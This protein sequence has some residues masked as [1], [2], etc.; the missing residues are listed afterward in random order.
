MK[1]VSCIAIDDE[2][3]ALGLMVTHITKTPFL[4]L[5]GQFDNALDAMEFLQENTVQLIFLDIHM[6]D[7]TG[8][9][10]ARTLDESCKVIFT[11]AYQKYAVEGF[12]LHALDYLLKPISYVVFLQSAT[13]AKKHFALQENADSAA[14]FVQNKEDDYLF[15]KV[16]MQVKRIDYSD[17]LYLEGLKDYV[18]LHL[19]SL[20]TPLV[21][22]ATM[23]SLETKLPTDR[24][25][26]IHRSYIV[27]LEKIKAIERYRILF[28]SEHIPVSKQYKE[29]FDEFIKKKFL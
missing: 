19:E 6:P 29:T 1:T 20:K 4:K 8:I 11:T 21:F 14:S 3:L 2:P 24:F 28:G 25:M 13:R 9:E 12:Q 22:H 7:F 5:L 17:I 15:I 26:R 10:F 16:D 23:K 18:K 27:N